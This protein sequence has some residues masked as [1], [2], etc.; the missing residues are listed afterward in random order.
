MS[1]SR[2]TFTYQVIPSNITLP[3]ALARSAY[4]EKYISLFWSAY[5]PGTR[6]LPPATVR[7]AFGAWTNTLQD[8]YLTDDVLRKGFLAICLATIGR[9]DG[10]RW[11]AEKGLELYAGALR[12][13]SAAL[14]VPKQ[15]KERADELWIASKLFSFHEAINGADDKH[16]NAQATSWMAH[17]SGEL[18]LIN[19]RSPEQCIFGRAHQ[20]FVDGRLHVAISSLLARKKCPLSRP[21]WKTIPWLHY[22]KSPKDI[23]LDILI[24][25]PTLYEEIDLMNEL[26]MSSAA[27]SP[28]SSGNSSE[29]G[30]EGINNEHNTRE[31][32][33]Q[34]LRQ[35]LIA[36][37]WDLDKRLQEWYE[38]VPIPREQ[39]IPTPYPYFDNQNWKDK[40]TKHGFWMGEFEVTVEQLA[41]THTLTLYWATCILLYTVTPEVLRLE[42]N[43]DTLKHSTINNNKAK[44]NVT[45][46]P[47]PCFPSILPARMNPRRYI[48]HLIRAIPIFLHPSIGV[49]HVHLSTVPLGVVARELKKLEEEKEVDANEW[50]RTNMG[51]RVQYQDGDDDDMAKERKLLRAYFETDEARGIWRFIRGLPGGGG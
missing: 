4:E 19:S 7:N 22:A 18:A 51:M 49:F 37:F 8:L 23:L 48:R 34:I 31:N 25:I 6:L 43:P 3:T 33:I 2:S 28:S 13:M 20:L 42:Q 16:G 9:Q 35:V 47:T 10:D 29:D 15:A 39:A 14:T 5:L 27:F 26:S 41:L 36:R 30:K 44:D 11:M 50:G 24:D 40:D 12:D 46:L 38:S 21:E 1:I 32:E 45:P 17:S